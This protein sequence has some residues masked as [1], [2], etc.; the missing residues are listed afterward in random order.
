[1]SIARRILLSIVIAGAALGAAAAVFVHTDAFRG[2][3]RDILVARLGPLT[4]GTLAIERVSGNLYAQVS[5]EGVTIAGAGGRFIHVERVNAEYFL[6]ALLKNKLAIRTADLARPTVTVSTDASGRSTVDGLFEGAQSDRGGQS[7]PGSFV[8]AVDAVHVTDGKLLIS[9]GA[10]RPWDVA[11]PDI[12]AAV[13]VRAGTVTISV[14]KVRAHEEIRK[15]TVADAAGLVQFNGPRLQVDGLRVQTERSELHVN[16]SISD[17]THPVF[18]LTL[19]C[20]RIALSDIRPFVPSLRPRGVAATDL[21][22]TGSVDDLKVKQTL[23]YENLSV[24][25]EADIT[26]AVPAISITS[27]VRGLNPRA[28]LPLFAAGDPGAFPAGE[29]AFD[30]QAR[31][32][33]ARFE[34]LRS[35]VT[36]RVH[37]STLGKI[38]LDTSVV[39]AALDRGRVALSGEIACLGERFALSLVGAKTS[40]QYLVDA[41][42]IRSS[43]LN[44]DAQGTA[45]SVSSGPLAVNYAI[46]AADLGLLSLL[47]PSLSC[48]GSIS[49][50]GTISGRTNAPA[51][52]AE[53]SGTAVS[54]GTAAAETLSLKTDLMFVGMPPEGTADLRLSGARFGSLLVDSLAVSA[55]HAA[56]TSHVRMAARRGADMSVE[57]DAAIE[58]KT[59]GVAAVSFND[60]KVTV[61]SSTWVNDGPVLVDVT[62][63]GAAIGALRFIQ[64]DQSVSAA[65]FL[66]R[67]R[68][69]DMRLGVRR[70]SISGLAGMAGLHLPGGGTISA[71]I[72]AAGSYDDPT[73]SGTVEARGISAGD[74]VID[75]IPVTLSYAARNLLFGARVERGGETLLVSSGTVPVDLSLSVRRAR[76]A[77]TGLRMAVTSAGLGL[78]ILPLFTD[79]I[80]SASGRINA[81]LLLEGNPRAP[82]A[83]GTIAISD[84]RLLL[85]ATGQE[86]RNITARVDIADSRA[87]IQKFSMRS[88]QG[89]A[90]IKGT[91][92]LNGLVPSDADLSLKT[93]HFM[94][95]KT[96]LFT[97]DLNSDIVMKGLSAAGTVTVSQSTVNMA[98]RSKI[99]VSDIVFVDQH[100]I[101]RRPAAPSESPLFRALAL[102]VDISIPG[103]TWLYG[104]GVTAELNGAVNVAKKPGGPLYYT[105]SIGVTRGMYKIQDRTL[106]INEGRLILDGTDLKSSLISASASTRIDRIVIDV[107]MAGTIQR[108][109]FIFRSDPILDRTD[110]LSYLAFGKPAGAE[111]NAANLGL[112]AASVDVLANFA[113]DPLK[114]VVGKVVS[115]DVLTVQP[116]AGSI[117]VGK[118]I[119]DNLFARYEWRSGKDERPKTVLEYIFDRHF[120]LVSQLGDPATSG[121]DLFWKF[122]Y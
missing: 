29:L 102:D 85:R 43:R 62:P 47:Y 69:V 71:D 14:K 48:S 74:M 61:A 76:L 112:R 93:W 99:A 121:V 16:G 73:I 57:A 100:A 114:D 53:V 72:V 17:F 23:S 49:S 65:G 97:G 13:T 95:M 42:S 122:S 55:N 60:L 37:P 77:D 78:G 67:D 119:T 107:T 96:D 28:I 3:V 20:P 80:L 25:A 113:V 70:A 56:Q 98:S 9:T 22:V 66:G 90:E 120:S 8:L 50:T 41:V 110:I 18:D 115:L 68:G 108:P 87:Q 86:Y 5:L 103:K 33:G 81:D 104:M 84:G 7:G 94:V 63:R 106:T 34:T 54:Y 89:T 83:R 111:A 52:S 46:S 39:E 6:P 58:Q 15:L 44:L 64:G 59:D 12:D 40:A 26:P 92:F 36:L 79:Q 38:S 51:V 88:G 21:R 10:A 109:D 117:G 101:D 24:K 27:S 45:G 118:Y 19:H 30:V 105:G 4:G 116:S 91:L 82:Q 75:R 1:M 32:S 11:V 35:S 2:M 31:A